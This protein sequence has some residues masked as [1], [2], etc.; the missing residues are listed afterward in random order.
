[1]A[2]VADHDDLALLFPHLRDLDMHL[3]HQRTC[4]VEHTQSSALGFQPHRLRY[5]VRAEHDSAAGGYFV[6]L[7]NEDGTF[8]PQIFDD[9]AIV[10]HFMAHVDRSAMKLKR[11]L[12]NFNRAINS[13][14]KAAGT[15]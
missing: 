9:G 12:Y 7:L 14:A 8:G 3:G 11:T 10:D 2:T 6:E 5:P 15:G 4:C 1:M 13:G